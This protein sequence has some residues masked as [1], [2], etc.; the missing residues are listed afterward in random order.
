MPR[1]L[2]L[3]YC[4]DGTDNDGVATLE[5]FELGPLVATLLD[6]LNQCRGVYMAIVYIP[7][8]SRRM[9]SRPNTQSK[10]LPGINVFS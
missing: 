4:A 10:V 2:Y 7:L 5:V 9:F 8:E 3:G 1:A 6:Y